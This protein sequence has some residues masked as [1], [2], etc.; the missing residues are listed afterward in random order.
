MILLELR[1][2]GVRGGEALILGETVPFGL[3]DIGK[4]LGLEAITKAVT[5]LSE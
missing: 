3:S 4:S 1:N 2:E 5:K